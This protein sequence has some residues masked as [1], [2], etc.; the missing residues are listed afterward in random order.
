MQQ[1][2]GVVFTN[3]FCFVEPHKWGKLG[4][5][6]YYADEF[7]QKIYT[8]EIDRIC[9]AN[10]INYDAQND[11]LVGVWILLNDTF[12]GKLIE[13]PII[14]DDENGTRWSFRIYNHVYPAKLFADCTEGSTKAIRIPI[15]A[16]AVDAN[17]D[18]REKSV[19]VM[20]T[21]F[22]QL[23]NRFKKMGPFEEAIK[24]VTQ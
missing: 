21:T 5:V 6:L 11:Q 20:N 24:K 1:K 14:Y 7:Q 13:R 23:H 4:E 8:K 2:D 19:L 15:E 17:R 12:H 3:V 18:I 16:R 10:G 22:D 9:R